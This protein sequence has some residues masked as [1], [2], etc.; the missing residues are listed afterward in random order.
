[1]FS[2]ISPQKSSVI[3]TWDDNF[4]CHYEQIAPMFLTYNHYCTFYI[5]PGEEN[6]RLYENGYK[7]IADLGFELGSHGHTHHHFSK[8]SNVEFLYQLS[9][10]Q[11]AISKLL[12]IKPSTFA[13]PH[14]DFDEN[15]LVE[16]RKL[17]FETRNTLSNAKRFSL[18][19]NINM[20]TIYATLKNTIISQNDLVFSGHGIMDDTNIDASGYE[21][22]Y[23]SC[24]DKII[25]MIK[26][27]KDLEICTFL[28]A[29]IKSYIISNC[30]YD[31]KSFVLEQKQIELLKKYGITEERLLNLI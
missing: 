4:K 25:C 28:Q 8:L 31:E 26:Q 5:N 3:F 22:I 9:E 23:L 11:K 19:T 1:M 29:S 21:P 2:K 7:K 16:A 10:S 6:F 30:I 12:G 13:F 15:M 27:F 17:Y 18:K 14:H 24:L 20:D